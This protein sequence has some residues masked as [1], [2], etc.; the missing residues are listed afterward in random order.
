MKLR[1]VNSWLMDEPK[2]KPPTRRSASIL[3][4]V[5]TV[6]ST[7]LADSG[8]VCASPICSVRFE[9]S[10]L[11]IEPKLYCSGACRQQAS[12]L[13]RAA[14]LLGVSSGE[15]LASIVRGAR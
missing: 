15:E 10:G 6:E 8:I 11:K 2:G 12:I 5:H 13:G 4:S 9:R 14:K 7:L 1:R 3:P